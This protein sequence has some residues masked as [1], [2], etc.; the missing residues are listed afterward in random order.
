MAA[1]NTKKIKAGRRISGW[2]NRKH[3]ANENQLEKTAGGVR[4]EASLR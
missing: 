1:T 4:V 2:L 3:L